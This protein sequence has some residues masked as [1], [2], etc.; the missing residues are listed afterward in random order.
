MSGLG[1]IGCGKMAYA[2]AGGITTR[3]SDQFNL[4]YVNDIDPVREQLFQQDYNARILPQP[5][6]VSQSDTIIIAVKPHQ[7]E[8]VL[9]ETM[10]SWT[11]D[12]ILV[13]VAAGVKTSVIENRLSLPVPV[14]RVMPNLPC[15]VG[16]GVSALC[17]GKHANEEHLDLVEEIFTSMGSCVILE[18][19]YMDVVTA[20]SGS[21]PAYVFLVVEAMISAAIELGL[22]AATARILVMDTIKGSIQMLQE[23]GE[24]PAVLRE[25]VSSP[26]GTTIAALRQMEKDGLRTAFFNG[27]EKAYL[28]SV[29]LG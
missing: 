27:I 4:I 14:V 6:V 5:E 18:E 25:Q 13:S 22:D 3:L 17:Q 16:S 9:A 11:P 28:R 7:V 15:L 1:I 2:L 24:H 21:G 20:I 19:K 26:A 29:E 23:S 12:K 8:Q 10:S